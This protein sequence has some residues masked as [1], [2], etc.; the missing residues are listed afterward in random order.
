[1]SLLQYSEVLHGPITYMG[2][3][4]AQKVFMFAKVRPLS[5]QQM[6]LFYG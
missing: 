2:K 6:L 3:G 5:L 1:M 4:S